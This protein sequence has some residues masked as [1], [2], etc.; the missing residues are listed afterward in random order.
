MCPSSL[1]LCMQYARTVPSVWHGGR[2]T[3]LH[4][5]HLNLLTHPVHARIGTPHGVVGAREDREEGCLLYTS[6]AA[7]DM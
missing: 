5:N 3:A 6:D 1:T 4:L 7:D 2:C